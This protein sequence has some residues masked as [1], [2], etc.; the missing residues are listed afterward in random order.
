LS[1]AEKGQPALYSWG[2]LIGDVAVSQTVVFTIIAIEAVVAGLALAL[3]ILMKR[4][5]NTFE[6]GKS[7]ISPRVVGN[8]GCQ[9]WILTLIVVLPLSDLC[10]SSPAKPAGCP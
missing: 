7:T 2:Y 8:N 3:I 5:W 9:P 6:S 10:S 1:S 4:V